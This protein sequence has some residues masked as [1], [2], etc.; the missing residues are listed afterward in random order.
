MTNNEH[1]HKDDVATAA[2]RIHEV[3]RVYFGGTGFFRF[4]RVNVRMGK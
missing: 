4:V 1:P 3:R 2:K